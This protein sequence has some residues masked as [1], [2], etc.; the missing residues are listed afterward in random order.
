MIYEKLFRPVLFRQDSERAHE[1]GVD[2]MALLAKLAPLRRALELYSR[3]DAGRFRPVKVF[4][5]EFPNRVGL[6]AGF[7]KNARAWPA[8]ARGRARGRFGICVHTRMR[9]HRAGAWQRAPAARASR[10]LVEQA[11]ALG[12]DL[13]ADRAVAARVLHTDLH[14]ANVLA[15][16]R[17]PWLVI[18][19]KPVNGD[20]HYE[21]A[22]MLWNRWDDI[23]DDV[24]AGVRRRLWTL[25]DAAGFDE[26]RA[27]A[28]VIVRMVHNAMW[29]CRETPR[30]DGWLTICVAVAKAVAD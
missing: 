1:H 5:L 23:A 3:L 14:Y 7:D 30:A 25:V 29:A 13:G 2:A 19:P 9:V 22:P 24:R 8:A 21:I 27:R 18:D 10:R 17:A 11:L 26:D 28:W 6:A 16:D 12:A 20:P 15:S 4:G